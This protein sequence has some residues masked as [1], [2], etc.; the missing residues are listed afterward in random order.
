[1]RNF[2]TN[3][4]NRI[5]YSLYEPFYDFI[6]N[7]FNVARR[8][9]IQLLNLN[10]DQRVLLLGAGTGIDLEFL[11]KDIQ[12]VAIDITPAMIKRMEELAAKLDRQVEALV[13]DGQTLDFPDETFDAVVLHLILAVIPDPYACIS[14]AVRVLKPNGQVAIFDKFLPDDADINLRRKIANVVAGFFFSEINR[15][16]QP[17]IAITPLET[18]HEESARFEKLGY[19]I[20]I[21]QKTTNENQGE[22]DDKYSL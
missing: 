7:L 6:G 16:L 2:N 8:R 18:I 15:R 14:E 22:Y 13:M 5:R 21:L 19:Q 20:T 17:I 4:W 12:V 10:P 3:D 9:S 11:P 1:M